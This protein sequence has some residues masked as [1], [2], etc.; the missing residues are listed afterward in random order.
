MSTPRFRRRLRLALTVVAAGTA[1]T[2]AAGLAVAS[3]QLHAGPQGDGTSITTVGW[4]VTPVGRQTGLGDKPFASALSPDGSFLA[5]VNVGQS[6]Q[7]V[8][9]VDTASSKVVQTISYKSPEAVYGSLAFSRDGK[10]LYVSGGGDNKVRTYD[11]N[12]EKLTETASIPTF[13]SGAHFTAGVAVSPDGKSLYVTDQLADQAAVVDL[14]TPA[15]MQTTLAVGHNPYTLTTSPDGH[16][17]YVANQGANTVTVVDA[18]SKKATATI[19]VGTHPDAV[20]TDPHTGT[21]YVGNADSDSVSVVDPAR[22]A[23]I[24]TIEL[25]PYRGA[26]IGSNPTGLSLSADGRT[27]Y[28]ANAGDNDIDVVRLG[29]A[30]GRDRIDGMIPAAWYPT[31]VTLYKGKLFVTNAKGLGAGPNP[32]GP[33]PYTDDQLRNTPGW[34]SQY[35][36]SMIQGTLSTVPVPDQNTL[37]HYTKQVIS[38]D[39]FEDAARGNRTEVIPGRGEKSPIQHVIYIVK[40]NRTFD[41]VFGSLGKGNGDA[42]INLFGDDS[43]PNARALQ[44]KFVTLDNFYAASEVS[45]DG[46][47]W[48]TAANANPYVQQS[49]LANYG[50]RNKPYDFEGG[51]LATAPNKTPTDAYLWDRL[52]DAKVSYKNY[53]FF[54]TGDTIVDPTDPVLPANTDHSFL[55]YDLN[56]P[57]SAGS[58]APRST[59][60][61]T[62]PRVVSW[63]NAFNNYVKNK[64]LPTVELLRLPNDHTHGTTPG[65]P[66]PKAYVADNDYALGRV[67][68][69]VSHSPYWKSTAIFVL[70]DDA[71]AGPDH[72][73]A[74][75]TIAQVIS[76]Y[77][78][79]GKVDSTFYSTVSML[80]TMELLTGLKPMTQFDAAATPMYNSFTGRP[81]FAPYQ[82]IK[83]SDAILQEIN[84]KNAPMAQAS[85]QQDFSKED[86][87]DSQTLNNAIWQS[88]KGSGSQMP[89]PVLH[90]GVYPDPGGFSP[91][92]HGDSDG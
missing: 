20:I 11:V 19:T 81:N 17:V 68:D 37:R 70:E 13:G 58:W 42:K 74:H 75:R 21:L 55:G 71:Q 30:H 27:L 85:M 12:G 46:W 63:E 9:V 86:K 87:A 73:D 47:N 16:S 82:L 2:T 45:A 4:R 1:V 40:E 3:G 91:A 18:A 72:V 65:Y 28:V 92:G 44:R 32:N 24:R 89:A 38:N 43:A 78:Q 35:V 61:G 56:C 23:T 83:P 88:V 5:V 26:P 7:S 60:C 15:H 6:I 49:W 33:N 84:P 25:A 10:K 76:P 8:Q 77:T 54:L 50:G 64:N 39:H 36:G 57:D 52:S 31:G 14:T 53:G 90:S 79:T 66:T 22:G 59:A 51:N 62:Q 34:I 80:R 41:Q 29:D 67:V 48:S 69:D